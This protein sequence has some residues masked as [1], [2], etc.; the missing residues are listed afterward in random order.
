[1]TSCHS[2]MLMLMG[3]ANLGLLGTKQIQ[4]F[5]PFS[6]E[7]NNLLT[8]LIFVSLVIAALLFS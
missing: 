2:I 7:L 8:G 3:R 1:M 6:V 5:L 4:D